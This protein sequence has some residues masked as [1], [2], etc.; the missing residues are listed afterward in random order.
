MPK[1]ANPAIIKAALKVIPNSFDN[2]TP[3]QFPVLIVDFYF[4]MQNQPLMQ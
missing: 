1:A 2:I 3:K 4:I